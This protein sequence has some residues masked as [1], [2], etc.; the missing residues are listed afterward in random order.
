MKYFSVLVFFAFFVNSSL[1]F[2][3]DSKEVQ[4]MKE[5]SIIGNNELPSTSFDL[6]WQLPSVD[7]RSDESPLK[8]VP[9][10]IRPIEPF[11]YKQQMH[12]SKYLEVDTS[13]FNAR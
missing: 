7:K 3:E 1:V 10:L 12:F 2:G 13:H 4:T 6:P 8:D 9:G 5:V 11:R